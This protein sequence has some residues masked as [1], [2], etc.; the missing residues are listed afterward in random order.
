MLYQVAAVLAWCWPWRDEGK[1]VWQQVHMVEG[2]GSGWEEVKSIRVRWQTGAVQVRRIKRKERHY[3][4]RKMH[5]QI[6]KK[7]YITLFSA[8]VHLPIYCVYT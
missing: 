3:N 7:V 8:F 5:A 6:S 1:E 2:S 4:N